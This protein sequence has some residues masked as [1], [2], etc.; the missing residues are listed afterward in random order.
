L[1]KETYSKFEDLAENNPSSG[2]EFIPGVEYFDN[3]SKAYT[4]LKPESGFNS[5]PDFRVLRKEELPESGHG[6]ITWGVMYRSYVINTPVYLAWLLR[7]F[8][9]LGGQIIRHTLSAIPEAV[10]I[11]REHLKSSNISF[12]AVINASGMGFQDPDCYPS[13]GQFLLISN[14]CDRTISHQTADGEA[15]VI[16]PRP[17]HGGTL[18]GGTKEVNNW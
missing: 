4:D 15:T 2:V 5:W 10:F 17:L 8:Q 13:R 1:I 9:L 12:D 6:S 16:I 14:P 11:A 7:Q 3:P 18:I